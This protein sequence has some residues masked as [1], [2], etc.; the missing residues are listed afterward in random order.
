[1]SKTNT[2]PQRD[3]VLVA[4]DAARAQARALI[5]QA[6]HAALAWTDPQ[7]LTPGISRIGFG[8]TLEGA[9]LTLVST[10]APHVAALRAHPACAVMLGEV[11]PGGDPL[12]H[13]RLMLRARAVFIAADD[14]SRA[15]LRD[16]WLKGHPKA[17]LYVDFADF[18]FVRLHPVSGLLNAGFARAFHLSAT[19]LL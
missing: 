19:D 13:P 7:S 10:L 2:P 4:D 18:H 1:M 3:P 16:A 8:L 11:G 5:A 12:T 17:A 9:P 6:T 14:P 15:E